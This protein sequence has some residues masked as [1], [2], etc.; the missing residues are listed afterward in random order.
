MEMYIFETYCPGCGREYTMKLW[1]SSPS[2]LTRECPRCGGTVVVT[3][4][5]ATENQEWGA[6]Q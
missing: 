6:W 2:L 5:G 4:T 1:A 3:S